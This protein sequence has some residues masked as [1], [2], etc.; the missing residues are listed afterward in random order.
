M[1]KIDWSRRSVNR[2]VWI[3][4]LVAAIAFVALRRGSVPSPADS[5]FRVQGTVV[6][7]ASFSGLQQE[8]PYVHIYQSL[9]GL[10]V[11]AAVLH[12]QGISHQQLFVEVVYGKIG[13][14]YLDM[15]ESQSA[16]GVGTGG[17]MV[18]A[19]GMSLHEGVGPIGGVRRRF[20]A[21]RQG[22]TYF[23]LVGPIGSSH[24]SA[25]LRQ[26]AGRG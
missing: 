17:S 13:K 8:A 11:T 1:F 7:K 19:Y 6:A 9:G 5:V 24:F 16:L 26:I 15:V 22:K 2:I 3:L 14:D 25:A 20:A 10:P 23:I 21:G 4:V 12:T 18:I